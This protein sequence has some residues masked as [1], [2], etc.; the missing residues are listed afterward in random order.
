MK[1]LKSS[2]CMMLYCA[3]CI[4]IFNAPAFA[5]TFELLNVDTKNFPEVEAYYLAKDA[6]GNVNT[7][8][9]MKD[10]DV[11]LNGKKLSTAAPD[12][13]Q[14]DCEVEDF[15][16]PF[17]CALLLD[18]STSMLDEVEYKVA[19]FQW[20][21]NG[22][23]QFIDSIR[24]NERSRM[25]ILPFSTDE[26]TS[27]TWSNDKDYLQTWLEDNLSDPN[28]ATDFNDAMLQSHDASKIGAINY[29]KQVS[30]DLP[31]FVIMITD[32]EYE[33]P[34]VFKYQEVIDSCLANEIT[35]FSISVQ[36]NVDAGLTYL[37]YDTQGKTY[38]AHDEDDI[39][40]YLYKILQKI[41]I[42][43]V[44]R[45]TYQSPYI[46]ETAPKEQTLEATCKPYGISD[47]YKY[48]LEDNAIATAEVSDNK[49][50]IGSATQGQKSSK[51]QISAN[52]TNF[53]VTDYAI[54]GDPG[55]TKFSVSPAPPF[56]VSSTTPTEITVTYIQDPADASAKY[57][58]TFTSTPC[59]IPAVDIIAPCY[60]KSMVT[61][62]F[63]D[64]PV[65]VSTPK[66]E[67][68]ILENTT[69]EPIS[70]DVILEG[71]DVSD[72]TIT[73]GAGVFTI[74]PGE[75]LSVSLEINP[76]TVG[77]KTATLNYQ[78]SNA[79]YCGESTTAITANAQATDFPLD[80][81]NFGLDRVENPIQKTFTITN[82]RP[83]EANITSMKLENN[84]DVFTLITP[85]TG[86]IAS[87]NSEDIVI[88]FNPKAEGNIECDL[89]LEIEALDN[90]VSTKVAG[91]GGLPAINANG[92]SFASLKTD[93]SSAPKDITISNTSSYMNMHIEEIRFAEA[94]NDFEFE[95]GTKLTD[96]TVKMGETITIPVIFTPTKGGMLSVD[97]EII[98]DAVKGKEVVTY[99]TTIV[100]VTGEGLALEVNPTSLDF[101]DILSCDTKSMEVTIPNTSSEEMTVT[102]TISGANTAE[103]DIDKSNFTIPANSSA[104]LLVGFIPTDNAS[105]AANLEIVTNSGSVVVPLSGMAHSTAVASNFKIGTKD[106]ELVQVPIISGLNSLAFEIQTLLPSEM[107]T[108]PSQ[109]VYTLNLD[110]YYALRYMKNS[111]VPAN[112]WNLVDVNTDNENMGILEFTL[113][114]TASAAKN[115]SHSIAFEGYVSDTDSLNID[116]TVEYS[117]MPCLISEGDHLPVKLI[118]CFTEGNLIDVSEFQMGKIKVNGNPASTSST[119]DYSVAYE[120]YVEIY[121]FD[122]MGKKVATLKD[123]VTKEGDYTDKV[124][125]E[126]LES[127]I[128]NVTMRAGIYQT[129][130]R[131]A[132]IK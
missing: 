35:F 36:S 131:L 87:G 82:K 88:E 47:T 28:G 73:S 44:C 111:F 22:V 7:S 68:C 29:L 62:D 101:G 85:F 51:F 34:G 9:K 48:T 99:Q 40:Y 67:N 89:V 128:Y 42:K 78:I 58:L 105:F 60:G 41:E 14:Q 55:K 126:L 116:L 98:N 46:C 45:F 66:T 108:M 92:A 59:E 1:I 119:I 103:F 95:T 43:N 74:N 114:P 93:Q 97:V 5:Q 81:Y 54:S 2:F 102:A 49:L 129:S 130:T 70:G 90:P 25:K 21:K 37:A 127:G 39:F 57:T 23:K 100:K 50:F 63:G 17:A 26:R 104:K 6:S 106:L 118:S 10:F 24:M 3:M 33:G 112:G 110:Y 64:V 109:V 122:S 15:A 83:S 11:T 117:N 16:T 113:E 94:T 96:L 132:I 56:T 18:C 120:T 13:L 75:C 121:I 20:L 72:F 125:Y 52:N 107:E 30:P 76:A 124:P 65:G 61:V 69:P 27:S 79:D 86:K 38:T 53:S 19:R 77:N 12:Y 4:I 71:V 8:F 123:G 32:G 80:V 115:A 31:K 91:I 84:T